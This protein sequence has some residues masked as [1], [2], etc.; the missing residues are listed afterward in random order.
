MKSKVS[1]V[2]L[3]SKGKYENLE[4]RS[5]Q[6]EEESQEH[7]YECTEIRK[8]RENKT[9]LIEF[10]KIYGENAKNQAEIA[11]IFTEMLDI[12]RKMQW[13]GEKI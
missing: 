5:C 4:C 7:V 11:K 6:M 10:E 1:D 3:N 8:K 2:K 13:K 12:R 9:K